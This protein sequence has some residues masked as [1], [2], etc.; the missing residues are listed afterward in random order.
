MSSFSLPLP[1]SSFKPAPVGHIQLVSQF[2]DEWYGNQ[3]G[4]LNAQES[5]TASRLS[6][7]FQPSLSAVFDQ[8]GLALQQGNTAVDPNQDGSLGLH[9]LIFFGNT[10]A[11]GDSRS[12]LTKLAQRSGKPDFVEPSDMT[13]APTPPISRFQPEQVETI[14]RI[15]KFLDIDRDGTLSA[16]ETAKGSRVYRTYNPNVS[17]L[18]DSITTALLTGNNKVDADQDGR[19]S[20]N[21][22][23]PFPTF[24]PIP[25][26]ELSELAKR[27]GNEQFVE[28]SDFT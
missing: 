13:I 7:F 3:D 20:Y 12:E 25:P 26:D 11:P 17:K 2:V 21:N 27:S 16:T 15:S 28:T 18:L 4:A 1:G 14:R 5:Q 19:M 9:E 10:I 23:F 24:A 22:F 6:Q 8:L